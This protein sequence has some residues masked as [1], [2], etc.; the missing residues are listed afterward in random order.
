[1]TNITNSFILTFFLSIQGIYI[2][3][4]K[5]LFVLRSEI[6]F[7]ARTVI[8]S[9]FEKYILKTLSFQQKLCTLLWLINDLKLCERFHVEK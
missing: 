8:F 9:F 7:I 5:L 4:F 2:L 3:I 6:L 1:M